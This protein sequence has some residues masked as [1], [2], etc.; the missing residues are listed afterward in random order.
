MA[1]PPPL[2]PDSEYLFVQS[3]RFD[4]RDIFALVDRFY[5][6]VQSDP[7]LRV[8]FASVEDWPE[9]I[10][11]LTHFWWVRFGGESYLDT[12]YNPIGKHFENGFTRPLLA[13]WLSLFRETAESALKPEQAQFWC[14]L[15]E[16]MGEFLAHRNDELIA[17][18]RGP[19]G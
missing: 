2:H 1:A 9:H 4:H 8:P 13:R 15:T 16:R 14:A 11:R 7:E 5:T 18:A 12:N 19:T 10:E 17:A 6:A 3:I